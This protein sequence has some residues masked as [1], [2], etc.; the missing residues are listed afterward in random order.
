MN[1]FL[2]NKERINITLD[3][4]QK[5]ALIFR[6]H[7]GF[8]QKLA[9]R[10]SNCHNCLNNESFES[11]LLFK[12]Y[13]T[14]QYQVI[15]ESI[16][17]AYNEYSLCDYYDIEEGK[18]NPNDYIK[19]HITTIGIFQFNTFENERTFIPWDEFDI[20]KFRIE[21]LVGN[22]N[23]TFDKQWRQIFREIIDAMRSMKL[24]TVLPQEVFEDIKDSSVQRTHAT[25]LDKKNETSSTDKCILGGDYKD[26][27]YLIGCYTIIADNEIN[28]FE[29]YTLDQYLQITSE[30]ELYGER[31]K[32]FS[33]DEDKIPF[34]SL[35]SELSKLKLS[36]NQKKEIIR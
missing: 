36:E 6:N 33:D 2:E 3:Q 14:E 27:A 1:P 21:Y 18:Y 13:N 29:L 12:D 26:I 30:S 16:C 8:L 4:Q 5:I 34:D 10:S 28:A 19:T 20:Y 9:N 11:D 24:E 35:L 17:Y 22:A 25:R 23:N 31:Q 7:Y 32:I 15:Y